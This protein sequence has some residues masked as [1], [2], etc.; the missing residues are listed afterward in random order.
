MRLSSIWRGWL[1]PVEVQ[2]PV[3]LPIHGIEVRTHRAVC[4]AN[5]VGQAVRGMRKPGGLDYL[6]AVERGWIAVGRVRITA[7]GPFGSRMSV[8]IL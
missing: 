6:Y 4:T 8:L 2:P 5:I 1:L 7:V 3:L